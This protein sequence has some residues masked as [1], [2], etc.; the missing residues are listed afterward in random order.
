MW[1]NRFQERG[2]MSAFIFWEILYQLNYWI[3]KVVSSEW[4][5]QSWPELRYNDPDLY[6]ER[7]ER[8]MERVLARGGVI[9]R[10]RK[11]EVSESQPEGQGL[12]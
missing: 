11:S 6:D 2:K 1:L 8:K 9:N 12:S 10:W 7:M 5:P 4:L 3:T